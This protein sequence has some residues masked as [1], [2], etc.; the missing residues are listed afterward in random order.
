M[1]SAHKFISR[2][3]VPHLDG[4]IVVRARGDKLQVLFV[5][6]VEKPKC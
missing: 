4:A 3:D 6:Q 1:P 2:D 5:S